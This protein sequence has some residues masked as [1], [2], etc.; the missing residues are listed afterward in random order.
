MAFANLEERRPDNARIIRE[1][2]ARRYPRGILPDYVQQHMLEH[3]LKPTTGVKESFKFEL[4]ND[5]SVKNNVLNNT[6]PLSESIHKTASIIGQHLVAGLEGEVVAQVTSGSRS[7]SL[8]MHVNTVYEKS[9]REFFYVVNFP[10]LYSTNGHSE[11][12]VNKNGGFIVSNSGNSDGPAAALHAFMVTVGHNISLIKSDGSV[13]KEPTLPPGMVEGILKDSMDELVIQTNRA[14]RLETAYDGLRAL[15][16]SHI[17]SVADSLSK[18]IFR[19]HETLGSAVIRAITT[20]T[21]EETSISTTLK[22]TA[23]Q[24]MIDANVVKLQKDKQ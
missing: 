17:K 12:C 13:V 24:D 2:F 8:S 4:A 11:K 5:G 9:S 6:T 18:S 7:L 14:N 19:R 22:D 3:K 20:L 23:F 16:L 15:V 1:S 10:T 21:V